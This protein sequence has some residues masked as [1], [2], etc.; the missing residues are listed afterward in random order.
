ML[1]L[2]MGWIYERWHWD[3]LRGHNIHI[4]FHKD[5]FRHSKVQMEDTYPDTQQG[6]LISLLLYFQNKESK[7]KN[8]GLNNIAVKI[9]LHFFI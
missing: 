1:V 3:G 4:K 7:L 9:C 5:L 6:D 8:Q 2:L